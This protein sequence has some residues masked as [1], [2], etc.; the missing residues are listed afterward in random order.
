MNKCV[1]CNKENNYIIGI[2]LGYS[3]DDFCLCK[4]CIKKRKIIE[5]IEIAEKRIYGTN[6]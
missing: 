4:E 1:F 5:L 3:G 6:K 2:A